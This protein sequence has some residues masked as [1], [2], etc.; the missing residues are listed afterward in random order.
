VSVPRLP[1]EQRR[2]IHRAVVRGSPVSVNATD[3]AVAYARRLRSST[4]TGIACLLSGLAGTASAITY[5][6]GPLDWLRWLIA[7]GALTLAAYS[8]FISYRARRTIRFTMGS[9]TGNAGQAELASGN[10]GLTRW[11][12][13][14]SC[15]VSSAS[16]RSARSQRISGKTSAPRP[17]LE[18]GTYCLGG[19]RSIR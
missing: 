9:S 8:L 2:L 10:L 14:T 11:V 6:N 3:A 1:R 15:S 7:A 12:V 18:R 4:L 19:S 16:I 5:E 17:R 13:V